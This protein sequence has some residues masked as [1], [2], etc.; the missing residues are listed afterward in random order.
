MRVIKVAH[1][2]RVQS[3]RDGE[4]KEMVQVL[5]SAYELDDST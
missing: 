1:E 3:S 4:D 2:S 5:V